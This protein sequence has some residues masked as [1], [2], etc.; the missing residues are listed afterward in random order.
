[1]A[2]E[3]F[4]YSKANYTVVVKYGDEDLII[5]PF[6]SRI[7]VPDVSKLGVLPVE[8]RKIVKGGN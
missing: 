4:L 1:M 5:P 8:I 6:A 7:K 3:C 2:Q